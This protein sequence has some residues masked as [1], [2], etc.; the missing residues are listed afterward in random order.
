MI[1]TT[2]A[3]PSARRTSTR[4]LILSDTHTQNP[5][6]STYVAY[7]Y[8]EPLPHANVLLH[9]GDLTRK[10][11]LDEYRSMIEVIKRHPAELK[12]VIAG[13]HDITLDKEYYRSYCRY[14]KQQWEDQE[15][16]DVIRELWCGEDARKNGLVYLEEGTRTF[17]LKNGAR[18]TVR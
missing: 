2:P 6:P 12:L 4:F 11:G 16:L 5:H 15:D 18:F 13:N 7:A 9:A 3:A 14:R 1:S 8:R 17:E 10:G